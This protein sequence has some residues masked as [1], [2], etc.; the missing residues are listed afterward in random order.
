MK[1]FVLKEQG[2]SNSKQMLTW[3]GEYNKE[4]AIRNLWDKKIVIEIK[5]TVDSINYRREIGR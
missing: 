2:I 4:C 5:S 1:A 3:T